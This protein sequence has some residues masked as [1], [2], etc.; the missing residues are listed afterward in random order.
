MASSFFW[1]RIANRYAR[2]PLGDETA[3]QKKLQITRDYLEL[4]ME[5]LEFGCGTGTTAIAHAPFVKHILA[6]DFS[7]KM[8]EIA[9]GKADAQN[10]ENITF[11]CA[12]IDELNLPDQSLD[13]VMGHS[14]LHLL[15]NWR[16]VI[17]KVHGKLKPGGTFITSTACIADTMPYFRFIVPFM[18]V[19]GLTPQIFTLKELEQNF[20]N[21]GFEIEH[22][23]Q[24]PGKGAS[25]FIVARKAGQG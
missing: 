4:D 14:I 18:R 12:S 16:D 15:D 13:V 22:Q 17:T 2:Q 6:T 20:A 1:N 7:A 8:I 11:Q 19:L 3:Y 9:Q 10:I 24:P 23:W 5:V 21:A 25:L